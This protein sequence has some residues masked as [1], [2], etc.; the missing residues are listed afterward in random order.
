MELRLNRLNVNF[1]LKVDL[2]RIIGGPNGRILGPIGNHWKD[3]DVS[4]IFPLVSGLFDVG[5]ERHRQNTN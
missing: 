4:E 1:C 3:M 2:D 5:R